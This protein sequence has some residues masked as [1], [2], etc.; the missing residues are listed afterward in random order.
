[1]SLG[2]DEFIS[3]DAKRELIISAA[4]RAKARST[5]RSRRTG[6]LFMALLRGELKT[7]ASSPI[8]Y[9]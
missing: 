8:D 6:D 9:L 3:D 7:I 4:G 5:D 1:M 2:L